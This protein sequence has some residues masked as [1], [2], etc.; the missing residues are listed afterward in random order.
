MTYSKLAIQP[1][2][3]AAD[4]AAI[5]PGLY[6]GEVAVTLSNGDLAAVYVESQPMTNN[7]GTWFYASARA[8]EADGSTKLFGSSPPVELVTETG[9]MST[10]AETDKLG[11][12]AIANELI[13][14]LLGEPLTSDPNDP[15]MPL[16][17]L[18]NADQRSIVAM[19]T[20]AES[21]ATVS[22][23]GAA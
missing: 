21:A 19:L 12:Q 4:A 10:H 14:A 13:K 6:P 15:T 3:R 16:V 9:H 20:V 2:P 8:I 17:N 11:A 23:A 22:A 18:E 1:A 7:S 5:A